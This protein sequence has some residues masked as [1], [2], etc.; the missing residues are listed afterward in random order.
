M[1]NKILILSLLLLMCFS[2]AQAEWSCRAK[3]NKIQQGMRIYKVKSLIGVPDSK[4][5]M[6]ID[7][8]I[9]VTF[10]YHCNKDFIMIEFE[11]GK[12]EWKAISDWD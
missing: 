5:E 2:F 10:Y 9:Y 1:K 11:D 3:Y 8:T 7:G 4:D 6:E 12:V